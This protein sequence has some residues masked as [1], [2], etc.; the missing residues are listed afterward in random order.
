MPV[1]QPDGWPVSGE[2]DIFESINDEN[3]AYATLHTGRSG[4]MT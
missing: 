4:A 3:I 1:S 2:I